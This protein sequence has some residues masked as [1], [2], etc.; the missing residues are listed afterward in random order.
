LS[1]PTHLDLITS[2]EEVL[3]L[4]KSILYLLFLS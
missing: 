1:V 3:H 4:F 2:L